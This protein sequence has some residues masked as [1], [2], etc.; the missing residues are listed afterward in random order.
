MAH[1]TEYC[2]PLH[3]KGGPVSDVRP[4]FCRSTAMQIISAYCL[5]LSP[6]K[7]VRPRI[8]CGCNLDFGSSIFS[9]SFK[10]LRPAPDV[11]TK[12]WWKIW[13]R[14][15]A[16]TNTPWRVRQLVLV[17]RKG[18][19]MVVWNPSRCQVESEQMAECTFY[20]KTAKSLVSK[21]MQ[22]AKFQPLLPF[23]S[24]TLVQWAHFR[25]VT[26]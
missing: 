19:N 16:E 7:D 20:P 17:W 22:L 1:R 5:R 26:V 24:Q 2:R 12:L 6:W 21:M 15:H 4:K 10:A 3:V 8:N 9:I 25:M 13:R 23:A 11:T 14:R 18:W